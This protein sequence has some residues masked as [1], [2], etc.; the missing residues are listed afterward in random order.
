MN[1]YLAS[2]CLALV[3]AGCK[4]RQEK[5][6][7]AAGNSSPAPLAVAHVDAAAARKIIAEANG[8]ALTILDIR[9]PEEFA[10][11]HLAGA[12]NIDFNAPD[13]ESRLAAIDKSK[14]YLVHCRSGG[15]STKSLDI[16]KKLEFKSIT[17]L[18]GGIQ[19]WQQAG[20]EVQK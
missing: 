16:F 12:V 14:T 18:D 7:S 8:A 2:L 5:T 4:D 3:L 17:H 6:D 1:K 20:G 19:A 10:E 9:T 13:F 11:G 15:R